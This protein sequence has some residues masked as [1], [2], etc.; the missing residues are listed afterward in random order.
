MEVAPSDEKL[1]WLMKK[2]IRAI[3]VTWLK[4]FIWLT[5]LDGEMVLCINGH[6]YID[7]E[8]WFYSYM[9]L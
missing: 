8:K 9:A 5:W 6:T 1:I 7:E 2:L 3:W 4:W